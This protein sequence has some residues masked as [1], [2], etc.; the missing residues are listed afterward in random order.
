MENN[1]QSVNP[2]TSKSDDHEKSGLTHYLNGAYRIRTVTA[3]ADA[4]RD[5]LYFANR[6]SDYE[7]GCDLELYALRFYSRALTAAE[8]AANHAIDR[9]RFGV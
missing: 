1:F 3:N 4:V 7:R 9:A 2:E 6:P 8:L 5:T